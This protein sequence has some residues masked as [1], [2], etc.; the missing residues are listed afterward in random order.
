MT[1]T[2]RIA[3]VNMK[4]GVGK[5]TTAVT[6]ASGLAAAGQRVLLVDADPQGNVGHML[7]Q[8]PGGTIREL[9][10]GEQS[11]DQVISRDVRPGLDV[12][13]SAPSA[14]S[15]DSQLAGAMQR[16]TLLWRKLQPLTGYDVLVLDSSPAMNLLAYN[17]L[18]CAT[19][20]LL[21]IG[22]DTLALTG[23]H[24]TLAGVR[25]IRA[26]WPDRTMRLSMVLP[27]NVN[28]QT[29]ATRA[30]YAALE[31]D[32]ELGP[33]V[34]KPGV[35]Q[36]IDLVYA[37]AARQTIWEYAPKSRAADDYRAVLQALTSSTTV[38]D[39]S[40]HATPTQTSPVL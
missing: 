40:S 9:M 6:V 7:G 19:E 12:I 37:T 22:M 13:T 32:T 23:A 11:L 21:P 4:G 26:L 25:E 2:R 31:R 18:L 35:R 28:P 16:E 29:H 34:F 8:H 1:T 24:Q 38:T 3:V 30:M 33:A 27:T 20:L 39:R 5:T 36:C 17:A 14:F 15:L 10:L